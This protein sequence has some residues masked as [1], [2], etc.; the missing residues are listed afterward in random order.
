M[1]DAITTAIIIPARNEA[2]RIGACLEA[3]APQ[4]GR[5]AMIVLV[6]NNC[7]DDTVRAA[8]GAL[9][10]PCLRIVDRTLAAG[11]GVGA[12]RRLGCDIAARAAPQLRNLLTTDADCVPGPDWI[13][14]NLRHL[15][16]VDAVCGAV[17]PLSGE[18]AILAR[19]PAEAVH[20]EAAYRALV[21]R[22][23]A[24]VHPEPHNPLP[25]HGDA[26]G[27]SLAVTLEAYGKAGGFADRRTAEDRDLVRRLRQNGMRVRHADDVR[28]AASCRLTG[29][30]PG[31]MAQTLRDR[32]AGQR[33]VVDEALPP[34]EWLLA[35]AGKGTL[36][37]WPPELPS[38]L[39]LRPAD[40]P[41]QIAALTAILEA[42]DLPD[43]SCPQMR[44]GLP[45]A[46]LPV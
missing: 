11:Q 25:H 29:R 7:T 41:G 23:Y 17:S 40:L 20:D 24:R 27:A 21:L 43:L 2:R 13:A 28:V 6:A 37:M 1:S 3:L 5:T 39:R 34:A 4:L 26:P 31:G 15:A 42:M 19:I 14:A 10:G 18:S 8:R 22:F 9:R 36:P 30:A 33:Y 46:A 38:Q 12:A 32:L 35:E 44:R 16:Q 45:N